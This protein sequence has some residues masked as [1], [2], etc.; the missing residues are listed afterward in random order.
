MLTSTHP[1]I[2]DMAAPSEML[3]GYTDGMFFV[4]LASITEPGLV[5]PAIAQA[6]GLPDAGASLRDSMR[7]FLRDKQTLLVLD[8]FEHLLPS[9]TLV[10][11]FVAEAP[12]LTIL[13]TSRAALRISGEHILVVP[14]L[15]LPPR[16]APPPSDQLGQYEA[17]HLF[18]DRARAVKPDFPTTSGDLIAVAE[19]CQQ[20]DGLPLAIEL[21]AAR[22]VHLSPAAL[23]PHLRHRL[24]DLTHG[25]HDVPARQ[26]TLRA[27]IAW[28]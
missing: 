13:V 8:N 1:D 25:P 15:R 20:L 16:S 11:A 23:L 19:I 10:A 14:P 22:V 2:A 5:V 4:E 18:V 12:G 26:Q 7:D 17:V 3:D 24:S 9:A 27:A 6:L 28:S 21:A